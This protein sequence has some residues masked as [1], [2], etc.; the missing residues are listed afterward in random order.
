MLIETGSQGS[1][2]SRIHGCSN[3]SNC[4]WHSA[5]A[6]L[7]AHL[8]L[9]RS[10]LRLPLDESDSGSLRRLALE[11]VVA[12]VGAHASELKPYETGIRS[13]NASTRSV[14]NAAAAA[15][16]AGKEGS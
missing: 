10:L 11:L 8:G 14:S 15:S 7:C 1:S 4:Q 3:N 5:R 9:M 12:R 2:A 13:R 16:Y 6:S